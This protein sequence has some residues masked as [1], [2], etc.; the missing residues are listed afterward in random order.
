MILL[1]DSFEDPNTNAGQKPFVPLAELA[2]GEYGFENNIYASGSDWTA[3]EVAGAVFLPI[4]GM[5]NGTEIKFWSDMGC[6]WTSTAE[7][8]VDG[9]PFRAMRLHLNA[10]N[11]GF[12]ANTDPSGYG[13]RLVTDVQ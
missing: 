4:T 10:G 7:Q 8:I 12:V 9:N 3:M 2:S 6:Y 5:R 1:P 13:V 11:P